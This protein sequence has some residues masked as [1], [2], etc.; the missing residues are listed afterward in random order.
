MDLCRKPEVQHLHRAIRHDHDVPGLDVP[1]HDLLFVSI[2]QSGGDLPDDRE[3]FIPCHA[4]VSVFPSDPAAEVI[5]I[6]ALHDEIVVA[7]SIPFQRAVCGNIGVVEIVDQLEVFLDIFHF[8]RV[9]GEF[10]RKGFEGDFDPCHIIETLVNDAHAALP[11]FGKDF[12][13]VHDQITG[14]ETT[15]RLSVMPA[16]QSN[17]IH[18]IFR[19]PRSGRQSFIEIGIHN[20]CCSLLSCAHV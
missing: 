15:I 14:L 13:A 20:S 8:Q 17:V 6:H 5:A 18:R 19:L 7:V 4:A 3:E 16:G 10:R 9:M 2:I 12:V 11:Q 1:V